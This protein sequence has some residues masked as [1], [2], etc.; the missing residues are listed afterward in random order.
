MGEGE[1]MHRTSRTI[2][3][4]TL[5]TGV[6]AGIGAVSIGAVGASGRESGPQ[7]ATQRADLWSAE[8]WAKKGEVSLYLFRKRLGAPAAD[9]P[10]LPV[11]FLVHGSSNS[12]RTSFDL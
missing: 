7:A 3:R 1:I 8:Y 11:L 5:I 12:S 9:A 6:S 10:P 4:R 2:G